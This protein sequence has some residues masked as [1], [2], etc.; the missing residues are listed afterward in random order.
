[1]IAQRVISGIYPGVTT[2]QLDELAAETGACPVC[3]FSAP[4]RVHR[5]RALHGAVCRAEVHIFVH[6]LYYVHC[7]NFLACQRRNTPVT[8]AGVATAVGV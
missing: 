4:L 8:A 2:T 7:G 3:P 6:T 1:M 5:P